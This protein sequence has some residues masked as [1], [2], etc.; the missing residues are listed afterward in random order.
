MTESVSCRTH[1]QTQK[2]TTQ[3]NRQ[4]G[5]RCVSVCVCSVLVKTNVDKHEECQQSAPRTAAQDHQTHTHSTR[6]TV[7]S[8]WSII[9][10][11]FLRIWSA[12]L[13]FT[14]PYVSSTLC[15]REGYNGYASAVAV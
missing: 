7:D 5:V 3:N 9:S 14:T 13:S 15:I 6:H 8:I 11:L 2:I 1:K 10:A 4:E 12:S